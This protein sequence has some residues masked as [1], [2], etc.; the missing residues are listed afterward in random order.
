MVDFLYVSTTIFEDPWFTQYLMCMY[1]SVL[2]FAKVEICP[3]TN[4]EILSCSCIILVSAIVNA[5][6]FGIFASLTE[7][8]NKREINFEEEINNANTAMG[9]IRIDLK[10]QFKVRKFIV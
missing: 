7:E 10:M 5:N 9:N 6:I 8:L 2:T 4:L 3:R 1:C